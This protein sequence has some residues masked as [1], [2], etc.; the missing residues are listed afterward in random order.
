MNEAEIQQVNFYRRRVAELQQNWEELEKEG[1]SVSTWLGVGTDGRLSISNF[2]VSIHRIKGLYL[3]FRFLWANKEA[4]QFL[5]VRNVI[6]RHCINSES[7]KAALNE[8]KE[9]W[10]KAAV[11]K[12]WHGLEADEMIDAIF[13]GSVIHEA[14][15]KQQALE[16]I[17]AVL[18]EP[19]AH[20]VILSV[21]WARMFPLKSLSWML[22]PLSD[23]NQVVQIPDAFA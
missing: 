5:K 16:R 11:G 22:E 4:S 15:D 7:A 20:H 23:E 10:C 9:R 17:T 18:A 14:D 1:F 12:R 13:Y 21:I 2:P 19:A 3:D 6:G 8:V